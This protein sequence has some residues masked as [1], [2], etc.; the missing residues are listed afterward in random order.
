[1]ELDRIILL[2]IFLFLYIIIT[3]IILGILPQAFPV[4]FIVFLAILLYIVLESN[5]TKRRMLLD[6]ALQRLDVHETIRKDYREDREGEYVF[7]LNCPSCNTLLQLNKVQWID[8][9]SAI[10][11]NCESVV[12]AS[13]QD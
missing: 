9:R 8:A 4:L 11:P 7:P 2:N 6:G 13:F 3:V 5:V 12:R 10:C 1:M